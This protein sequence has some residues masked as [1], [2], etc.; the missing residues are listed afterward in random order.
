M[1]G[2]SL[3]A[4]LLAHNPA[5]RRLLVWATGAGLVAGA[6]L[7]VQAWLISVVVDAV[8][9]RGQML[10]QVTPLLVALAASLL[11]RSV[12]LYVEAVLGQRAANELKQT[13]RQRL[14]ARLIQL[15]PLPLRNERAGE[16]VST[17]SEGV[18]ALDAF[19]ALFLPAQALAVL[20]TIFVLLAVLILDPWTTLILLFAAPMLLFMLALIGG[21]AKSL[22]ERRFLEL[23]WMSA[24]FLDMLQGLTTL[25]L[26][27]RSQEQAETIRRISSH[28]G[29]TTMEVLATAFQTSL[30]MEWAATAATALVAL[31]VSYRLMAGQLVFAPALAVLLLTPE[32]FLPLRTLAIRYHAGAAGKAAA[33]RILNLLDAEPATVLVQSRP[34]AVT[35]HE[36][37]SPS[38]APEHPPVGASVRQRASDAA[39]APPAIRFD[40]VTFA[41]G[42]R[43]ALRDC[44]FTIA[45]GSRVA[46]VGATG[47][48]KSTVANLLL[49]FAEP[50]QGAIWIG[51]VRLTEINPTEWRR[52]VAWAPQHPHL[53]QGTVLDNIRLARPDASSS[54]VSAA[55]EAAGAHAFITTLPQGYDTPIGEQGVRLSGGQ[56]QRLALARAFLKDA[57]LLI[58]DEATAHLDAGNARLIRDAVERLTACRTVVI[59]AHRLE[60]AAA[61]DQVIVLEQGRVVESGAHDELLSRNGHYRQLAAS[62]AGGVW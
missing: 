33:Q 11:V 16:L 37:H 7:V 47:A 18:E 20:L 54:E 3:T 41:Y 61:A 52:R 32:F 35:R 25:K 48:G 36:D 51:D 15:G 1:P 8:F 31:E 17:V 28:Y 50:Q 9:L 62:L 53:F 59:I 43:P 24:F 13:L 46:L 29:K 60:L 12:A 2:A 10:A 58:L 56:R 26:F 34:A 40:R 27:G 42:D 22:T 39:H 49:H 55:A 19:V 45:P 38:V 21:R 4:R 14:T 57:P 44:S 30:V 5:A 6:V 23:S